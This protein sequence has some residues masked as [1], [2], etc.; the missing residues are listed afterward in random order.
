M[1]IYN[2]GEATESYASGA[3]PS[4]VWKAGEGGEGGG[5]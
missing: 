3:E 4:E 5:R 1:M 2:R